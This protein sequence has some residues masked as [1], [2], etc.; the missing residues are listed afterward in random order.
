MA[1]FITQY[2]FSS[3][4]YLILIVIMMQILPNRLS[5]WK[6]LVFSLLFGAHVIPKYLAGTSKSISPSIWSSW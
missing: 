4:E 5:W 3:L 6:V 1:I 2:F